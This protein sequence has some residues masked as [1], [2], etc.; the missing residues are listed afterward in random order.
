[1]FSKRLGIFL[2]TLLFSPALWAQSPRFDSESRTKGL[3]WGWG[4]S[5]SPGLPGYGHTKTDIAFFAF[6][7]QM[8]WFVTNRLELYGEATLLLYHLPEYAFAGGLAGLA[9][10][11][12][13]FNDRNWAPFVSAG[14]GLIW[15]SLDT[16]EIDRVFNFQLLD[17]LGVRLIP[18]KGPH[19]VL[20]F[21][22]HHTSN[23]GT[24][25]ENLGIN[26]ATVL[27]GVN[28]ILR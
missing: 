12:H 3:A 10:R 17:G 20:E 27:V 23:A 7:P 11:Y 19:W 13:F 15:T 22:N 18:E 6:H 25:G 28:W 26:A 21:R 1:V 4:H 5:W 8:G 16:L 24:A 9:G 2:L 14:A